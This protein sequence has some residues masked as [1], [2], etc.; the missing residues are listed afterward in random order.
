[1]RFAG[2]KQRLEDQTWNERSP[3]LCQGLQGTALCWGAIGCSCRKRLLI[4]SQFGPWFSPSLRS[5]WLIHQTWRCCQKIAEE[6]C[7]PL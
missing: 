7:E 2:F 5:C 1:M 6:N 3:E 4:F